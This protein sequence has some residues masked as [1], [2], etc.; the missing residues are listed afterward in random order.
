[1]G[2]LVNTCAQSIPLCC[3]VQGQ[4][5]RACILRRG[6]NHWNIIL[7]ISEFDWKA[8]TVGS[9]S[10]FTKHKRW[11]TTLWVINIILLFTNY[12]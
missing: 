1:M 3:Q 11:L 6:R 8:K 12:F 5:D 2:N 9:N 10:N 4:A 7:I